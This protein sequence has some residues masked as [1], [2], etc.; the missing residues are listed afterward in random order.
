MPLKF[1]LPHDHCI[2]RYDA[3]NWT[4]IKQI[5]SSEKILGYFPDLPTAFKRAVDVL[6]LQ[7]G[8]MKELIEIVTRLEDL[9]SDLQ[10]KSI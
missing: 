6:A 2:K 1:S 5:R 4:L 3:K 8:D 9:K 10:N 7:S